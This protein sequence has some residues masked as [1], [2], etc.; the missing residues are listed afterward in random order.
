MTDVGAVKEL[1]EGAGDGAERIEF[2]GG[3]AIGCGAAKVVADVGP[4]IV[5]G[6][7][8]AAIGFACGCTGAAGVAADW[9]SSKSSSPKSSIAFEA[10][11]LLF[12]GF[13]R[14]AGSSSK[15]N[16]SLAGADA[17]AAG[18]EEVD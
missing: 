16:R 4:D 11:L 10:G 14:G 12:A 18:F 13:A 1:A 17:G 3:G 6:G 7:E 8:K 5:G 2:V 15:L 9:K